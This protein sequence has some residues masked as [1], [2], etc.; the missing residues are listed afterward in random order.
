M[1]YDKGGVFKAKEFGKKK[2]VMRKNKCSFTIIAIQDNKIGSWSLAIADTTYNYPPT[3]P[4]T[5]SIH[6]QLAYTDKVKELI[7]SQIGVRASSKQ[8]IAAIWTGTD[9]KNSL[10]KQKDIY[11]E[12]AAQRQ[13]QLGLFTPVQALMVEL[14]KRADWYTYCVEDDEDCIKQLFF[15]KVSSQKILKYNHEVLLIN[16]TYKTTKYKMP[17]IIIS[18]VMPLNTSYYVAFVFV[19]KETFKVYKWLLECVKD[20]YEYLDIPDL[21]V[22]LTDAQNSLIWAIT[23]VYLLVSHL[24][25]LWHINK[26]VVVHCKKWFDN[27]TWEEFLGIWYEVLYAPT[28]EVF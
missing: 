11:N 5:H 8:V 3:L 26:N 19:S 4:G 9:E 6:R 17:L 12:R 16:A 2:T 13:K 20:L 14:H 25:C 18:G 15:V 21:D 24:L 1:Q 23:I 28:K 27:E 7:V 22:I 10:V